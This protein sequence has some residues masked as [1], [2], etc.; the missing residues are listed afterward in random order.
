MALTKKAREFLFWAIVV[1]IVVVGY[2][3][4][5]HTK[6]RTK[7]QIVQTISGE[8]YIGKFKQGRDFSVI[9]PAYVISAGKPIK[10]SEYKKEAGTDT[11]FLANDNIAY[12]TGLSND[13]AWAQAIKE[14]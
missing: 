11:L 13:S 1:L 7:Y 3:Y 8:T 10:F 5:S 9:S 4:Y 12:V 2:L 14:K 6:H